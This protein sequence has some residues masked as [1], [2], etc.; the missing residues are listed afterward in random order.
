MVSWYI[1]EIYLP[2]HKD[3]EQTFDPLDK[4]QV[5]NSEYIGGGA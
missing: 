5:E 3:E 4:D 1:Q 2:A